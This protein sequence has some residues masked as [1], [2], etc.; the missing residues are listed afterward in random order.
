MPS[1]LVFVNRD[2][3]LP[4][5]DISLDVGDYVLGRSGQSDIPILD[6]TISRQHARLRVTSDHVVITDLG[7]RNRSFVNGKSIEK[8]TATYGDEVRFGRVALS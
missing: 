5:A 6:N 4:I 7:S 2:Q 1:G 3:L 8:A